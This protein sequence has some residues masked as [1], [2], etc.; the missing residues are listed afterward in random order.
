MR[1]RTWNPLWCT[2]EATHLTTRR[3]IMVTH[4]VWE[5]QTSKCH[6]RCYWQKE[7]MALSPVKKSLFS[8]PFSSHTEPSVPFLSYFLWDFSS[9]RTPREGTKIGGK[10]FFL[11]FFMLRASAWGLNLLK[12]IW[13]NSVG[14]LKLLQC[15]GSC[16]PFSWGSSGRIYTSLDTLLHIL[17]IVFNVASLHYHSFLSLTESESLHP[18]SKSLICLSPSIDS[19]APWRHEL[20]CLHSSISRT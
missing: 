5:V 7:E 14:H 17:F 13:G 19:K 9:Q 3:N 16:W 1:D 15:D 6:Q 18:V 4:Q 12:A 2:S 8:R 10:K 11:C 20:S